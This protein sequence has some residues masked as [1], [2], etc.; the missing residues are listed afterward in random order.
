MT[1]ETPFSLVTF[2]VV[3]VGAACL[4]IVSRVPFAPDA[5]G[6][7]SK[8]RVSDRAL[9]CGGQT[10]TAMCACARLGLRAAFVG[11]V[12]R[13]EAGA[14]VR[15]TLVDRGVDVSHLGFRDVATATALIVIPEASGERMVLWHR[16]SGLRFDPA[17][18]PVA[19]L[20]SAR[21]VH[22]DDVDLQ[23]AAR[24]AAIARA[25]GAMVTTDIDQSDPA[26]LALVEHATHAIFADH[27]PSA[28]TGESSPEASLAAL[29][30]RYPRTV[31][32][33]TLGAQGAL[34]WHDGALLRVSGH[35]VSV[36]DTT[37]AGDVF[38]AGFIYGLC[39]AWPLERV[40]A[41]ANAAAAS[42]CTRPGGIDAAPTLDQALALS[43]KPRA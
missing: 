34:V 40:L 15:R 21:V 17:E 24:A 28:L 25:A 6:P 1:A 32:S 31:L 36:V 19:L 7:R 26:V 16:D 23:L 43:P 20:Q 37:G 3:G 18:V 5:S 22:L 41:F 42:S 2:D 13:D 30:A 39:Q 8:V 12:G 14:L 29:G 4:D 35:A 27:V 9:R 38:R 10:A 11:H 33:V